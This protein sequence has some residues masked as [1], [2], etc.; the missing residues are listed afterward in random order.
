MWYVIYSEKFPS[1]GLKCFLIMV[2]SDSHYADN[3]TQNMLSELLINIHHIEK[4]F[5]G[6]EFI[7]RG[8]KN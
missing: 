4:V 6:R 5:M 8:D 1:F 3:I 2:R 7:E